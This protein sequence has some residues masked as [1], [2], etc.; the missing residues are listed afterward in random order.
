[1]TAAVAQEYQPLRPPGL[2]LREPTGRP[3]YPMVLLEGEEKA[4]KSTEAIRLSASK[5]IGQTFLI[6]FGEPHIDEYKNIPGA[7]YEL[8]DHN[9]TYA[10]LMQQIEYVRMVAEHANAHNQPPVLVIIDSM[11]YVWDLLK[12]WTYERAKRSRDGREKLARDPDAEINPGRNLWND[13]NQRHANFITALRRIPGI[14]V[15]TGRGKWVSATDPRTGQPIQGVKEYTLETHKDLGFLVTCWVR[16]Y[17]ER[18]AQ[19][20]GLTSANPRIARRPGQPPMNLPEDWTLEWLIFE[21]MG[22]DPATAQVPDVVMPNPDR[23]PE[24]IRQEVLNPQTS[25]E[26][27]AELRAEAAPFFGVIVPDERGQDI[28]LGDL[29]SR[30]MQRRAVSDPKVVNEL[31]TAIEVAATVADLNAAKAK[32]IEAINRGQVSHKDKVRL[33]ALFNSRMAFLQATT[34]Q[35]TPES[36]QAPETKQPALT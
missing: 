30:V 22:I 13:A 17:R 1:L 8:V 35:E 6:G 19:L 34:G 32:T 18:P 9:G 20:V 12:R 28:T 27:L 16:M 21:Y 24:A 11:V 15:L 3:P 7:R 5:R 14:I 29:I 36:A 4:G 23:S 33:G 26:R 31:T 10:D 2:K 25:Y